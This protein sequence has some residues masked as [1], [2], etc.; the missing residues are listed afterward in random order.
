MFFS[1]LSELAS[2]QIVRQYSDVKVLHLLTDSRKLIINEGSLFFAIPGP[3]HDAHKFV[4]Q[5]YDM[6]I[7]SF[8][9]EDLSKIEYSKMPLANIAL[10]GNAVQALQ[11]IVA[12][13]RRRFDLPVLAITGSNAKTTVKEYLAQMLEG[14]VNIVKSPKSYNSQIGVPLSVWLIDQNHDL[15]IF[16]AGISTVGEM[17]KLERVIQPTIGIFTNIGTA[18]DEGFESLDQKIKEKLKL[19]KSV[20]KLIYRADRAEIHQNIIAQGI[21]GFTW[22]MESGTVADVKVQRLGHH[23]YSFVYNE[24]F[25]LDFP[26]GDSA[27]AENLI[28]CVV[29]LLYLGYS[30]KYI[31]LSLKRIKNLA[32]RLEL[33][34]GL[35]NTYLIDDTYNND[36][37]GLQIALDFLGQQNM[38]DRKSVIISD[39]IQAGKDHG[40]IYA[41]MTQLLNSHD[42]SKVYAI[43]TEL[44]KYKEYF[45]LQACFYESTEVFLSQIQISDFKDEIVLIKGARNFAFEKIVERLQ[46]KTHGTV[47]EINLEALAHNLNYY[48]SLLRNGAKVMAMVKAFAYGSGS[49]EVAQLLQ[50]H[51]V[52]YLGVAY[53][54]EAVDLRHNGIIMPIMV[55]NA[56]KENFETLIKYQ[57]EPEIYSLEIL[58]DLIDFV[59]TNELLEV[60][61]HI[62]VDTGMRRL[63]FELSDLEAIIKILSEHPQIKVVSVFSHLVGAD[64]ELHDDFSRMQIER[65]VAFAQRFEFL[66][67]HTVIKHICNSAGIVAYPDA[68]LDMVRLGVGLYGVE[69]T[70][71]E[72]HRLRSVSTLKS[73]IA[74]IKH[75]GA[76]ETVGYGRRGKAEVDKTI[77]TINIGYADGYSRAFSR[78][79]GYVMVQGKRAPIIGN[80]C[81]DMCMIDVTNLDV[82]VG[83]EVI[84]FGEELSIIELASAINTIPYEILTNVS[85]RV[86]RVFYMA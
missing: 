48:R 26:F 41:E 80:V 1:Q 49:F 15:G 47:L 30:S 7:R 39:L 75:I 68:Q 6:G 71:K 52:D 12:V 19:F 84:L 85:E 64:E 72:Q 61:I 67:G 4:K 77:A 65:F 58:Q 33:K 53:T 78:G 37:A 32:M 9:V 73:V 34:Q 20:E 3:R 23:K 10:V 63:G 45:S 36:L 60:K 11:D 69:A 62:D 54:D 46:Q 51:K 56:A 13:H 55:M 35:N 2:I 81:M 5:V 43:G 44:A 42:I 83:D 38:R 27:S 40:R 24:E 79:V 86:K 16:E 57:L 25:V 66:Y 31:G 70:Q 74:Q 76:G 82:H 50:Y 29:F 8:V 28:H 59:N 14:E 21:T 17:E 18:H 22:A